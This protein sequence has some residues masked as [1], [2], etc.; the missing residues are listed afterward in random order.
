[1]PYLSPLKS[2]KHD[3]RTERLRS[4]R[5]LDI[6]TDEDDFLDEDDF[7]AYVADEASREAARTSTSSSGTQ[8][9]SLKTTVRNLPVTYP[10]IIISCCTHNGIRLTPNACVELLGGEFSGD[11]LKIVEIVK[12]TVNDEITLRGYLFRR[13]RALN[14]VI[15]KKMNEVC[16]IIHA[17][18]DDSRDPTIQGMEVVNVTDVLKRRTV[19]MTNQP[20]PALSWRGNDREA[21]ADVEQ[22]RELV[23]RYKYICR[24][25]DANARN[26][27][28][29]CEKGF[30]RLKK[31]E[32]DQRVDNNVHDSNLREQWRGTTVLGGAQTGWLL[33]EKEFLRQEA[34]SH[35]G[36]RARQSLIA[37]SGRKFPL[38]DVM[39]RGSVGQI[40]RP[41]DFGESFDE[42]HTRV[43]GPSEL[44]VEGDDA[45]VEDMIPSSM[46]DRAHK[47]K[48][49]KYRPTTS[50]LGKR[51]TEPTDNDS[52]TG[53]DLSSLG[54]KPRRSSIGIASSEQKSRRVMEIN[55]KVK[56]SS[57]SGVLQE[58]YQGRFTSTYIPPSS[59][60]KERPAE[61]SLT[62]AP[63]KPC[64]DH[65]AHPITTKDRVMVDPRDDI[66]WDSEETVGRSQAENSDSFIEVRPPLKVRGH[67][68]T[69]GFLHNP[70]RDQTKI[71]SPKF[72]GT[73]SQSKLSCEL[74][75]PKIDK[76]GE[77]WIDLTKTR[78]NPFTTNM[79]SRSALA[80]MTR[81]SVKA[82]H[83]KQSEY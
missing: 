17:D 67:E 49:H 7:F 29:W 63:R 57:S 73:D 68:T 58:Q 38:L 16:W 76:D 75:A 13:T 61:A 18:D 52:N 41:D 82:E 35:R 5:V 71:L 8:T 36:E 59:L 27:Y 25:P 51:H 62:R 48:F 74:T 19:R 1:M 32:C 12:N 69:M 81:R 33:G 9:R 72:V 15:D 6:M 26:K 40:I 60:P 31:E 28:A 56:S 30:H 21:G 43:Y 22:N 20:F 78:T 80:S 83:F 54:R 39:K 23:C 11:F 79:K 24:Y 77:G 44:P 70:Q 65:S 34:I 53:A 42:E 47:R 55:A 3:S 37:L 66:L 50:A 2:L 14:G 64:L 10:L 46:V 4:E 45:D